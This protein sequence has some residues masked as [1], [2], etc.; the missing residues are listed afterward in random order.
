MKIISKILKIVLNIIFII[1]LFINMVFIVKSILFPNKVPSFLG[2]RLYIVSSGSIETDVK[3]GDFV[4]A[5]NKKELNIGD[6]VV[7]RTDKKIA[8]TYRIHSIDGDILK[9]ENDSSDFVKL[10]K[11]SIEGKMIIDIRTLGEVFLM[12]QNPIIIAILLVLAI[13]LGI[14]IY[15]IKLLL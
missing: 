14:C 5:K 12:L 7:V 8:T 10:S 3:L 15:K 6:I 11:N 9:L 2:Y 1:L 13:I 4:I